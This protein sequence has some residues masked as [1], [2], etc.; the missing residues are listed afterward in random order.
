MVVR[1]GEK[2]SAPVIKCQS[3]SETVPVNYTFHKYFSLSLFF[4]SPS[5]GGAGWLEGV[6]VGYSPSPRSVRFCLTTLP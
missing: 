1:Y 2:K 4:F 3:S 5:L 6:R